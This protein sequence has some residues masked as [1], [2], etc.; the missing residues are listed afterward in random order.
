MQT[1][2]VEQGPVKD[3]LVKGK[4]FRSEAGESQNKVISL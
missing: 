3:L 2:Q 1:A 4:A